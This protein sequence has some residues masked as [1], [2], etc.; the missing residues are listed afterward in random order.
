MV[1]LALKGLN[2][3][4]ALAILYVLVELFISVEICDLGIHTCQFHN[5]VELHLAET[6]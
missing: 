1:Y 2:M 6:K 4:V 5:D 3:A